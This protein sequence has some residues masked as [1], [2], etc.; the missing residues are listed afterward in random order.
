MN[1]SADGHSRIFAMPSDQ[2]KAE[3]AERLKFALRRS[4]TLV[5][6]ATDLARLFNLRHHTASDTDTGISVQSTHKLLTRRPITE[7][8]KTETLATLLDVRAPCPHYGCPPPGQYKNH[9]R[10]HTPIK[11]TPSPEALK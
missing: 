7:P 4:S 10:E 11:Y 6:G 1:A 9:D 2:A 8:D 3:F 5:K